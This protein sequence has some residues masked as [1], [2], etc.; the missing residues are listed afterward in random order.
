[1]KEVY[2]KLYLIEE[3]EVSWWSNIELRIQHCHYWGSGL[4]PGSR[5][6][7]CHRWWQRERKTQLKKQLFTYM[8]IYLFVDLHIYTYIQENGKPKYYL[9]LISQDKWQ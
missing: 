2:L 8:N 6:S 1:M 5:T 3:I 9:I 7:T 4:I